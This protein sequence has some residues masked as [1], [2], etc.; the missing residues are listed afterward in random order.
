MV[1]EKMDPMLKPELVPVIRS[2]GQSAR[3]AIDNMNDIVWAISPANETFQDILDRL[4]IFAVS[5]LAGRNI[6]LNMAVDNSL[7]LVQLDI[8][9]R[10]NVYLFLREAIHNVAKY[11]KAQD[12]QITGTINNRL[13]SLQVADDGIGFDEL[14]PNLGGNGLVNMKQRAEELKGLFQIHSENLKGTQVSLQ[15]MIS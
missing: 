10:K 13:I 6:K 11:S 12:C 1:A 8:Q 9:Q 7:P 15:F 3:T 2:M 5:V 14:S 4:Q